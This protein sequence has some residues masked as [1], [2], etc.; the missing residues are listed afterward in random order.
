MFQ[1]KIDL[2]N[3]HKFTHKE[4]WTETKLSEHHGLDGYIFVHGYL[5]WTYGT[6][7]YSWDHVLS[8]SSYKYESVTFRAVIITS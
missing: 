2:L 3:F 8:E 5:I 4:I 6:I 1:S 7:I